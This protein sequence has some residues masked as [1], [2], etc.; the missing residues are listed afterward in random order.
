MG[1]GYRERAQTE[2]EAARV[3]EPTVLDDSYEVIQEWV[4]L[5]PEQ[6]QVLRDRLR[7]FTPDV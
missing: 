6:L 2:M 1:L 4:Q 3:I 7:M 5:T